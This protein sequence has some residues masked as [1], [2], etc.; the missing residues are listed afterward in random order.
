[1]D[2]EFISSV[3][4]LLV[5][6]DAEQEAFERARPVKA[7]KPDPTPAPGLLSEAQVRSMIIAALEKLAVGLGAAVGETEARIRREMREEFQI[8]LGQLRAEIVVSSS[9]DKGVVD[10]GKWR[11]ESTA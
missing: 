8:A 11:N 9:G 2:P 6:C 1:M 5:R 4:D 3:N 10:L 7:P